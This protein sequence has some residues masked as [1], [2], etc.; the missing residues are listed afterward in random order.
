MVLVEL[1]A[2]KFAA[3]ATALLLT[4]GLLLATTEPPPPPSPPPPPPP[5]ALLPTVLKSGAVVGIGYAVLHHQHHQDMQQHIRQPED[6]QLED[7]QQHIRQPEDEQ[8][9]DEQLEDEQQ[10]QA[11]RNNWNLVL[12]VLAI[13]MMLLVLPR[14]LSPEGPNLGQ[15]VERSSSQTSEER[16]TAWSR[17]STVSPED[18]DHSSDLNG[19]PSSVSSAS[20]SSWILV[21]P[22]SGCCFLPDTFFEVQRENGERILMRAGQL[23]AGTRV[24]AANGQWVE[25][26]NPPEQ[27]EAAEVIELVAGNASL[28]V[29][30]EHRIVIP[31]GQSVQ[32]KELDVGRKVVLTGGIE[33]TLTSFIRRR[34]PTTVLKI[35]FTPDYPVCA[36]MELSGIL[37]RGYRRRPLRRGQRRGSEASGVDTVSMPATEPQ[38]TP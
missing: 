10:D 29:S 32:A 16:M 35:A 11:N 34:E 19:F 23:W 12:T 24:L 2:L 36:F 30:P 31:G 37:S 18:S 8:L 28:T 15:R 20:W 33:A 22:T 17:R 13:V 27:H 5:P 14:E 26:R 38:I 7:E 3:T 4:Q 21:H 25:V 9:E 6:E 1:A